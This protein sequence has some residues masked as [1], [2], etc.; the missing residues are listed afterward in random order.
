MSDPTDLRV[1][2]DERDRALRDIR[3]HFAAGRLTQDEVED[4]V[5]AVYAAGSQSELRRATRDL[6]VL[7]PTPEEQRAE[8]DHRRSDLRRQVLQQT[9]AGV[10][11]FVAC[12]LIWVA[13]GANGSFWP[14][15][16]ALIVA[17]SLL[18]NGWRL[19]G[20]APELDRVEESL[21]RR[22]DSRR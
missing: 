2:D 18:R 20:P 1:S 15:W 7:P 19:Y 13:S 11:S 3:E 17:V 16:I 22:R 21:A 8:L 14:V 5:Q 9:G 12:T 6:P 4:R 10:A